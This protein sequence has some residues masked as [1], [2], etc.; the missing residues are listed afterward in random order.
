MCIFAFN[1]FCGSFN[2]RFIDYNCKQILHQGW[3]SVSDTHFRLSLILHLLP[4]H[5]SLFQ[6]FR[7]YQNVTIISEFLSESLRSI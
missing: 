1:L 4:V 6:T 5:C 7:L 2:N 3:Y